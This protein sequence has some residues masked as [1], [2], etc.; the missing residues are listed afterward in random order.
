MANNKIPKKRGQ[1]EIALH[2]RLVEKV[3]NLPD[4]RDEVVKKARRRLIKGRMMHTAEELDQACGNLI[5]ELSG[6]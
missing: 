3:L 4:V 1:K 5:N 2:A 6:R